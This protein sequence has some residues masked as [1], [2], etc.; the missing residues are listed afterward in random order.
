ML[1]NS[2]LKQEIVSMKQVYERALFNENSKR[3]FESKKE[4]KQFESKLEKAKNQEI[5]LNKQIVEFKTSLTKVNGDLQRKETS[6]NRV[7]IKFDEKEKEIDV[8]KSKLKTFE[9]EEKKFIEKIK[10]SELR[11]LELEKVF[12]RNS[13]FYLL[14]FL[15]YITK[16]I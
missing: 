13:N 15:A 4:F 3:K 9:F 2:E 7:R 16:C 8:L 6:L 14:R 11:I 10:D 1:A 12:I 5:N